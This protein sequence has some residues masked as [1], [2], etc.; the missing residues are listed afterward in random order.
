[1]SSAEPISEQAS[2]EALLD[3]L[4][5]AI[6]A[7]DRAA[8]VAII[9]R[10]DPDDRGWLIDRLDDEEQT[11]LFELLPADDSAHLFDAINFAQ[12]AEILE[13]L[14]PTSAAAIVEELDSDERADLL[15]ELE[16]EDSEA[17]LSQL[18]PEAA[19]ETRLLMGYEEGTAGSL[20]FEEFLRF[21]EDQ[22]VGEVLEDLR[23]NREEYSTY[24]VQY[25]YVVDAQGRLTGVVPMRNLVFA[26][27]NDRVCDVM[28]A[29][30]IAVRDTD[31]VD[32]LE[33]MFEEHGLFGFPVVDAEGRLVGVVDREVLSEARQE[34]ATEDLL[35]VQGLMGREELR[36]MPVLQRSGRRLSWL[37]INIVLNLIAASIIAMHEETL[38]AAIALAVF[39]PI[40]SDMS[41]C[42]GNQAVAVSLR[43]LSLGLVHP[44]EFLR[45][46]R[47]EAVV[48][49]LNGIALGILLGAIAA[50]WK[51]NVWLGLVVGGALALNT[52][53]AACVG[54]LVPLV[55]RA[56]RQDP[57]LA[58][59]PIL[60][61]VTDMCGFFI[62][63][64][65]A[66]QVLPHLS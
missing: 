56:L 46:F 28:I 23:A 52:L 66:S 20:M 30:P 36:S 53:V 40:I 3:A 63:L 29:D 57:A 65:L 12:S 44:S 45:V 33:S 62:L 47:K 10:T 38:Q 42:S 27:P 39:L 15:N 19:T 1:M 58:S 22:T 59:G 55:L 25:G 9:E 41:G 32:D 4:R 51:G 6:E 35:K 17:I 50:F 5:Q 31:T 24:G 18:S 14:N 13:D 11:A 7:R 37:S 34:Q 43:E 16:S 8:A 2:R 54:G 61:T 64:T 26:R 49:V 60:T 48:G 21:R